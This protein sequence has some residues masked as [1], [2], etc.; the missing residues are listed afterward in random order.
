MRHRTGLFKGE[1]NTLIFT[2]HWFPNHGSKPHANIVIIHG[3]GEHSDRYEH[4]A[5]HFVQHGYGVCAL[6]HRG[7]GRSEGARVI[8]ADFEDYYVAD[9]RTYV[10]EI[11][12]VFP[13]T[14]L[15]LYGHSM[16]SLIALLFAFRYQDELAGVITTGIAL[17]PVLSNAVTVP[18]LKTAS[19]LIPG[20]RLIP[21]D[22]NGLSRDPEVCRAYQADPL[23]YHGRIPLVTL[24]ALQEA[25][26]LCLKRLPN[27]HIPLLA[28]HGSDDALTLV[29]GAQLV[30]ERSGAPD[31]M[32]KIYDGLY[33][34]IH[35][36]PEQDQVLAD[37]IEWLDKHSTPG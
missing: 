23:V 32:V 37:M 11:Q 30:L 28:M 26:D 15:F 31:T 25:A 20:A 24:A 17:K 29:K 7:H 22:A 34:E 5:A 16:G 9:L 19:S 4:V 2:Q 6:D 3:I 10:D 18:I 33:H 35:N 27:L 8:V 1:T 36:E 21:L 12:T 13:D 14:P